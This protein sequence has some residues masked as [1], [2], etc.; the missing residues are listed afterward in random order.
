MK[1]VGFNLL[2]ASGMQNIWCV[3]GFKRR[4]K[5]ISLYQMGYIYICINIYIYI[6]TYIYIYMYMYIYIIYMYIYSIMKTIF[7]PGHH[8]NGFLAT[9]ALGDMTYIYPSCFCKIWTLCCRGSLLTTYINY[10]LYKYIYT[11]KHTHIYIYIY[12]IYIHIIY[13]Y[14]H[15]HLY[16]YIYIYI[17]THIDRERWIDR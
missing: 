9:H 5:R 17:H 12:I 2:N 6:Y 4:E 7:P 15:T 14:V 10:T 16:I 1:W 11:H 13:T 8:H 3:A